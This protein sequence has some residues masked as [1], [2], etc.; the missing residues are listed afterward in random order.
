MS[1]TA[2]HAKI[3]TSVS[4]EWITT[5]VYPLVAACAAC[6]SRRVSASSW[7]HASCLIESDFRKNEL[8][9]GA[10]VAV[11]RMQTSHSSQKVF[12]PILVYLQSKGHSANDREET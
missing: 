8:P 2:A 4:G 6:S 5:V 10:T 9:S 1:G 11:G 12:C 3:A 7:V